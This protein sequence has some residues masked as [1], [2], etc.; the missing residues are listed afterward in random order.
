MGFSSGE[1]AEEV[2]IKEWLLKHPKLGEVGEAERI[3][4]ET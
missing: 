1:A 2:F 4:L 3:L